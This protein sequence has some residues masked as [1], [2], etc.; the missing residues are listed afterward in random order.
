MIAARTY[1]IDWEQAD[2]GNGRFA[3]QIPESDRGIQPWLTAS[4]FGLEWQ[5]VF[6][7]ECKRIEEYQPL[8]EPVAGD[9]VQAAKTLAFLRDRAE[10]FR[11]RQPEQAVFRCLEEGV[12]SLFEVFDDGAFDFL[13]AR[14]G[15]LFAFSHF[16]PVH[17][18][19]NC[20]T[21]ERSLTVVSGP[22][23]PEGTN[24]EWMTYRRSG[25]AR[26]K[27]LAW[28][29]GELILEEPVW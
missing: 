29:A 16:Q 4:I 1:R 27:L 19:W 7:G 20:Q 24:L 18:A 10:E 6:A 22:T 2:R 25:R 8:G 17:A 11:Q 13:L 9:H 3:F 26:G 15:I 14:P 5:W 21:G 23:P 28:A 12:L